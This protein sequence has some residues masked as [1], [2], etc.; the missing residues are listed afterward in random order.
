VA[1]LVRDVEGV[2]AEIEELIRDGDVEEI[3]GVD[4][5]L[6]YRTVTGETIAVSTPVSSVAV[7]HTVQR[8]VVSAGEQLDA[9]H[10]R[11]DGVRVFLPGGRQGRLTASIPPRV[12]GTVAFTLRLPQKRHTTLEDL[13][14]FGSLS[15]AAARFLTC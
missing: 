10:P 1:R 3:Y 14:G 11:A 9:S 7:L 6:T 2:G 15:A 5:E 8:L 4:G 12:D 13:V